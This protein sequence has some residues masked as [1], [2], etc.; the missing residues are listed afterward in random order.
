MGRKTAD[1]SEMKTARAMIARAIEIKPNAHFGREK[2]QLAAMDWILAVR[3]KK[4]NEVSLSSRT[5]SDEANPRPEIEGLSGLIVLGAAWESVDVFHALSYPLQTKEG[6]TLSYLALL[7]TQELL[8]QGRKSLA[9]ERVNPE[10]VRDEMYNLTSSGFGAGLNQENQKSLQEL[11]PK[12]RAEA[13]FWNSK[14]QNYM[15]TRLQKGDHPDTNPKFW[16][17]WKPAVPPSLEVNWIN[18][19]QQ[20]RERMQSQRRTTFIVGGLL[21]S[22]VLAL[23]LWSWRCHAVRRNSA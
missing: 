8:Q 2:Y 19:V 17:D 5:P 7:R 1:L 11:F 13:E 21:L 16:A 20:Q 18:S 9:P 22:T 14:R 6:I 12:L 15:L 3:N 10:W 4:N 23:G